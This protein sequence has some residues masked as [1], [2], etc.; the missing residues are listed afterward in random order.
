MLALDIDG[1]LLNPCGEITRRVHDAVARAIRSGM[2]VTLATGRNLRA[3]LPVAE[4]LGIPA[5]LVVN[6]GALVIH[7]ASG[8]V[9]LHRPLGPAT[10]NR[11]VALL[12][13]L[14][15]A[16]FLSRLSLTEPD[17]FYERPPAL[18]EADFRMGRAA[19]QV[20]LVENLAEIAEAVQPLKV[21][22]LD[23]T[24]AVESAAQHL[25]RCLSDQCHLLVT[26]ER[27]GCAL[28]E[29]SAP[30]VNKAAGLERLA[31]LYGIHPNEIVAFGDNRNDL[32]MLQFAGLGVAMGNASEEVRA[33]ARAITATNG[34]DGVAQF[35]EAHILQ[36]A[37]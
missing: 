21:M 13:Q 26:P 1:T 15:M 31:G 29:V 25:E 36:A 16:V 4:A 30:G 7:P 3:A 34:E 28:L 22:T 19:D 5:P 17:L 14:G 24:A 10:A 18:P 11:A 2:L 33:V 8:Q 9:L 37:S 27:P 32:E 12:Q 6:N 35:L 23:R 20:Q